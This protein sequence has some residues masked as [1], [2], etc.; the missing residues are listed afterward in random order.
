MKTVD[1][2]NLEEAVELLKHALDSHSWPSVED[3]LLILK[4]ELGYDIEEAPEEEE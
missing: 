3:A 2:D 1:P 4:E